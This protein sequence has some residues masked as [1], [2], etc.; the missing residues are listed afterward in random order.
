MVRSWGVWGSNPWRPDRR[1]RASVPRAEKSP[2]CNRESRW[3]VIN[4]R[5]GSCM[6]GAT[7]ARGETAGLQ[8]VAES[9]NGPSTTLA[10]AGA[11]S[12]TCSDG[13]EPQG[14]QQGMCL[15]L[16]CGAIAARCAADPGRG[17]LHGLW[18]WHASRLCWPPRRACG[19][20]VW[21][22]QPSRG[23]W[24]SLRRLRGWPPDPCASTG[25]A[26]RR[27][28]LMSPYTGTVSLMRPASS[29]L[30]LARPAQFVGVWWH[31]AGIS[32][33][34]KKPVR[35]TEARFRRNGSEGLHP[36]PPLPAAQRP[37]HAPIR[38]ADR[39]GMPCSCRAILRAG[40]AWRPA[41]AGRSAFSSWPA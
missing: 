38:T 31:P 19:R 34:R 18:E 6:P 1:K 28:G 33:M 24:P 8:L 4:K 16:G 5:A 23:W 13:S 10:A 29:I 35:G 40:L 2:L 25:P 3:R 27:L 39:P 7:V 41:P 30:V 22:V 26:C 12:S 15:G 11:L 14:L 9:A 20:L 37:C 21:S 17:C 36:L 32:T